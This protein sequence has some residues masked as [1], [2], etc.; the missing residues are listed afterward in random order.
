MEF[1]VS[2]TC[3]DQPLNLALGLVESL[4]AHAHLPFLMCVG[5]A[6]CDS[7]SPRRGTRRD[8]F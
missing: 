8:L 6:L 2:L 1:D 4:N 3:A 7:S 5:F